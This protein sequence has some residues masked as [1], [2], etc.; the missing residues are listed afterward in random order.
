VSDDSISRMNEVVGRDG[1]VVLQVGKLDAG[2]DLGV[3]DLHDIAENITRNL[4]LFVRA[5]TDA[6]VPDVIVI[7][8]GDTT[9]G[10]LTACGVTSLELQG[11]LQPG[12]VS[13]VS[14]DGS[15]A[16]AGS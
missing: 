11:E 14:T 4:G 7:I 15:I 8:G 16:G 6:S 3:S 12:T 1:V 9:N 2:E 13:A 10:V 5:I